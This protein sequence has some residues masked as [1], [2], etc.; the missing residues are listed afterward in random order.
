MEISNSF[1]CPNTRD[2]V[3]IMPFNSL[4]KPELLVSDLG[5]L[6]GSMNASTRIYST[7][8]T[9]PPTTQLEVVIM[10]FSYIS[11]LTNL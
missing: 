2:K 7:E 3:I 6:A 4:P 5:V 8:I 10:H 11:K 1:P 9:N